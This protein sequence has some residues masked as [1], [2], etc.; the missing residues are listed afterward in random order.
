[1]SGISISFNAGETTALVG[2][3]GSG[4]TTVFNLITGVLRPNSGDIRF[5]ERSIVGLSPSTICRL[6]I[7]RTYQDVRTFSL[8]TVLD[9]VAVA[10]AYGRPRRLNSADARCLAVEIINEL[11][12]GRL[13]R[14][15]PAELNLFERKQ[16]QLARALATA[17]RLLLLDEQMAGLTP[18]EIDVA[19]EQ[20]RRL[21]SRHG[22]TIVLIEHLMAAVTELA[23]RTIVLESGAVI[24]DGHTSD[25]LTSERVQRAYL[26]GVTNA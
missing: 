9:N 2:P 11:G 24:A 10:A 7:S 6:G 5:G 20:I 19:A 14:R 4:K 25:V 15:T 26:G 13:L 22:V 18:R 17:P 21:Q 16:V 12:I 3:N 23:V 8:M 1:M